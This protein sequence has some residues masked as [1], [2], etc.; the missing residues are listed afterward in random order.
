MFSFVQ[1]TESA[2]TLIE[3]LVVITII[4]II[5]IIGLIVFTGISK[6]A[7]D[8]RRESDVQSI[9][10]AYEIQY[11]ALSASGYTKPSDSHFSNGYPT[12]PE[13]GNYYENISP[14]GS[15]FIICAALEDNPQQTCT[16]KSTTCYCLI[17]RQGIYIAP[18]PIPSGMGTAVFS[19]NSGTS[20]NQTQEIPVQVKVRTDTDSANTFVAKFSFPVNLLAVTRIDIT[21][22]FISS[23]VEQYY[24]NNTGQI[25]LSGGLPN[26]GYQTTGTDGLMATVY[27]TAKTTGNLSL[28]YD[29]VNSAIYRNS[30]NVNI[31]G[32]T[33]GTSFT[34]TP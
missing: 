22:S 24:D 32:N 3:L 21:G 23:W 18:T 10:H 17:S 13:G 1:K 31:L 25:S 7:R 8:A 15:G 12:P 27:F 19:L 26:P 16:S 20:Y 6:S 4:A 29:S 14:N 9:A 33:S 34:I 11:D 28:N 5:S 2:F 30:D